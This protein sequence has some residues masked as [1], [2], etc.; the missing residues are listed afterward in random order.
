MLAADRLLLETNLRQSAIKLREKELNLYV[1]NFSAMATQAAVFAGFTTT[2]LIEVHLP[3]SSIDSSAPM[4]SLIQNDMPRFFLH[5]SAIIS[6]SANIIC[7]SLA[8]ITS[9]Y[10]SGKALRGKDGS[11]DEAVD[12]MAKERSMLLFFF[13]LGLSMNLLTVLC[14]SLAIMEPPVSYIAAATI[15]YTAWFIYSNASRIVKKFT[16][17][18]VNV[19]RLD[20]LTNVSFGSGSTMSNGGNSATTDGNG[21]EILLKSGANS[22]RAANLRVNIKQTV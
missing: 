11:M 4:I 19:T 13:S 12:A 17:N 18:D 5:T 2:C 15:I 20:D 8:T 1:E 10:G 22:Q 6:I 16:L 21:N 3:K 14:A 7:V 9:I